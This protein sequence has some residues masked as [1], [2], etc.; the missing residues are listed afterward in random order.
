MIRPSPR[1]PIAALILFTALL[2]V[3]RTE[4]CARFDA[5]VSGWL[6]GVGR[7]HPAW[8]ATLRAYT[9]AGATWVFLSV[10]TALC[11]LCLFRRW[12]GHAVVLALAIVCTPVVWSLLHLWLSRPRPTGG[13]V[14]LTSNGFPSGHTTHATVTGL[15]AVLLV[16]QKLSRPGRIALVSLAVALA[17]AVGVS[18]AALLAHWPLDVVGGWLLG[19]GLAPLYVW[20]AEPIRSAAWRS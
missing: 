17:L 18:R 15:L 20:A 5:A 4:P 6:L 11:V 9:D 16:G 19:I 1:L 7:A 12:Y 2:A 3:V 13:F 8:V 10:G 14:E